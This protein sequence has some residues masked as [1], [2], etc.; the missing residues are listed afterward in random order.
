VIRRAPR[1]WIEGAQGVQGNCAFGGA[2]DEELSR[3]DEFEF[4]VFL[5]CE[6]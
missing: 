5:G 2:V 3:S 6:N 4:A 1:A